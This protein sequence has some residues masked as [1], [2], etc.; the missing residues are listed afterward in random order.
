MER[1]D[2]DGVRMC[3]LMHGL[4]AGSCDETAAAVLLIAMG[5]KGETADELAIAAAV[6]REYMIPFHA[7]RSDHLDTCGTGGDGAGTFN[8]STATALVAA[9]A[10]VPVVKH[11]NRAASS[12]S[13][14]SADVLAALGV[15]VEGDPRSAKRC[16]DTVGMAF[17]FAPSFHPALQR[18]AGVRRRLGVSTLFNWIGPLANPSRAPYQLLGVGRAAHLDRMAGALARLGARRAF[19]VCG[20]D[21]L[22]EVSLSGPTQV[23]EVRDGHTVSHE[24]TPDDFGLAPCRVDEL[25]VRGPEE[26]AAA[27]RGV[28][29][30]RDGPALRIVLANAAAALLAAER[31]QTLAEGVGQARAA[32]ADGRAAAVLA[33]LVRESRQESGVG[34]H[35]SGI[36]SQES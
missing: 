11:G 35:G 36:S 14:S 33:G 8:I 1:R 27:I 19:A 7:G 23:R 22:D 20:R 30:G 18:L 16:L 17:C 21:G 3:E 31:V 6:L 26:S 9:G 28:L 34:S 15:A 12:R 4:V 2:L 10:G 29:E 32:V 5:M 24:W 13:G 25:R